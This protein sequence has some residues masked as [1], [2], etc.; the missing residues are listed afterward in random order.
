MER[1]GTGGK[2]KLRMA[3]M[4]T[5]TPNLQAIYRALGHHYEIHVAYYSLILQAEKDQHWICAE[6][7]VSEDLR[8]LS[9]CSCV[10]R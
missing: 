10:E 6:S 1:E 2:R 8:S 3:R 9:P 4:P 7:D 5:Q